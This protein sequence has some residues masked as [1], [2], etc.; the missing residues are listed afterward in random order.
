MHSVSNCFSLIQ[1]RVLHH[2]FCSENLRLQEFN[3]SRRQTRMRKRTLKVLLQ[4]HSNCLLSNCFNYHLVSLLLCRKKEQ[5]PFASFL[6]PCSCAPSSWKE[7]AR[8]QRRNIDFIT[9]P[10]RCDLLQQATKKD[11]YP[12]DVHPKQIRYSTTEWKGKT[13]NPLHT[14]KA[15]ES[16]PCSRTHNEIHTTRIRWSTPT[17]TRLLTAFRRGIGPQIGHPISR[18]NHPTSGCYWKIA[19]PI[20]GWKKF[21]KVAWDETS[22]QTIPFHIP[23]KVSLVYYPS[24]AF[25]LTV[26]G[27]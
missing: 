15:R 5:T 2:I 14:A 22:T 24:I 21:A 13:L 9:V 20:P 17:N 3:V 23:L 11:D 27:Q 12:F 19:F 1:S 4:W 25:F 8:K 16:L 6:P 7:N 10:S 18:T 26:K